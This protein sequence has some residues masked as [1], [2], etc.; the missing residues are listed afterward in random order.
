M[1]IS[2]AVLLLV[3]PAGGFTAG[4][5]MAQSDSNSTLEDSTTDC[6][7][8]NAVGDQIPGQI[9][10][11][12]ETKVFDYPYKL[13][14]L[15]SV[16]CPYRTALALIIGASFATDSMYQYLALAKSSLILHENFPCETSETRSPYSNKLISNSSP[17]VARQS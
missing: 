17:H 16:V 6:S 7:T 3:L 12:Q 14:G 4:Y 10:E 11:Q 2:L 1:S 9:S 5:S 8:T 13:I 15:V